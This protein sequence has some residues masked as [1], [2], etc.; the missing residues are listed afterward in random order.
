MDL[1][2]SNTIKPIFASMKN[3]VTFILLLFAAGV[4][5][6]QQQKSTGDKEAEKLLNTISKRYKNFKSMKA[7][8]VYTIES[9][10]DKMQEKQNGTL[11][12]KGNK[13]KLDIAGQMIICDNQTLWTYSKEVNEVQVTNYNP[14]E[15]A[16]RLDDIFTM[17]GKGFL[18]KITEEKKEG[19]KEIAIVEL[20]PKDKKKNYFKIKLTIDK[21]NQAITKSMVYDKNG[22]IHSYNITNQFP[23]IKVD[24]KT[25]TFDASK[26]PKVEVID[27]RN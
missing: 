26:Y 18:Y 3:V 2:P 22:S 1:L 14:K 20:T 19:A 7:D 16:I 10:A 27:L 13:F 24:D 21:T 9:K 8:F 4:S 23:N 6:Q 5:A 17:Y 15:N 11:F 12:V 25:F